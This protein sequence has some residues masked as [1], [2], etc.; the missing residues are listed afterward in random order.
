M[1]L[2][3]FNRAFRSQ[4]TGSIPA[5]ASPQNIAAEIVRRDQ[6]WIRAIAG[7]CLVL[8]IVAAAGIGLL[9]MGLNEFVMGVRLNNTRNFLELKAKQEA[10]GATPQNDGSGSNPGPNKNT[11][12]Q[13]DLEFM[14][15]NMTSDGTDLLHHSLP[16]I[17]GALA[18]LLL[19]AICTVWLVFASRR[20]TLNRIKIS[21][22]EIAEEIRRQRESA[23][24]PGNK[25]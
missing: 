5:L 12:L 16:Y 17:D 9:I 19:A 21:L 7:V 2:D 20:T 1:N 24:Q 14:R 8:W 10:D 13:D 23:A 15:K 11:S 4:V 22:M 6:R 18:A 25:G 3:D